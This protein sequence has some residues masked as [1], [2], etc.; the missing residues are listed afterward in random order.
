MHVITKKR[1]W[2]AKIKYPESAS[3]LDGWYRIVSKN[4]FERFADLK[5]TF[6]SIDKVGEQYVFDIGGNKLRL[7]ANIHFNRQ[8]IYIRDILTHKEYDK[9]KW[10]L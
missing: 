2:E 9:N 5:N 1:I 7:I 10:K 3:A 6:N 4:T 8:K